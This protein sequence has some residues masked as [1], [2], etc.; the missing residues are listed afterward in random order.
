LSPGEWKLVT[1]AS[2]PAVPLP[3]MQMTGWVVRK[4]HWRPSSASL[5][6]AA[7]ASERWKSIGCAMAR[8]TRSGTGVG[9]AVRRYLLRGA[10]AVIQCLDEGSPKSN[11][12]REIPGKRPSGTGFGH[13]SGS[14]GMRWMTGARNPFGTRDT[15]EVSGERVGLFR[16]D[17]LERVGG[18]KGLSR[19]P[20]S[21]E[22]LLESALRQC[23]ASPIHEEDVARIAGWTPKPAETEVPF[24][25]ARVV[26]P[27]YTGAAIL[28]DLAAMRAAVHR[29]GGDAARVNPLVPVDFVVDHSLHVD[30]HGRPDA[31]ERN[32]GLEMH[33]NRERYEFIRW[34][35]RSM[36]NFRV[37]PPGRGIVHQVN[38]EFL[39]RGILVGEDAHGK[40]ASPSASRSASRA[41]S[42]RCSWTG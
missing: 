4:T 32:A 11:Q 22:L 10:P 42:A 28:A 14:S 21:I 18:A 36:R 7:N 39:A 6:T 17:A 23:G 12:S 8:E 35:Q 3:L 19:L 33:R 2:I 25:P 31:A 41:W 13:A 40:L 1:D 29:A 5:K 26:M 15:L 30:V 9:P 37:V 24:L 38:L 20:V 16:L 27:D 34:A